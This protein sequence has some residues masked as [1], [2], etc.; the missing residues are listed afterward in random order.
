MRKG[1][2]AGIHET[3]ESV[4]NFFKSFCCQLSSTIKVGSL[5]PI[6]NAVTG[7]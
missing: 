5:P 2:S 1:K 3:I 7:V 6:E 4:E